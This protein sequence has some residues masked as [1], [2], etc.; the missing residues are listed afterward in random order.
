MSLIRNEKAIVKINNLNVR[1]GPSLNEE[2]I[3]LCKPGVY[4]V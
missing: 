2:A 4:R 3:E 1:K